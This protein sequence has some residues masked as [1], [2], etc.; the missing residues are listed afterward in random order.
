MGRNWV[1]AGLLLGFV[2]GASA[3]E[4]GGM[5]RPPPTDEERAARR[6]MFMQM[7]QERGAAGDGQRNVDAVMSTQQQAPEGG[8]LSTGRQA[9]VGGDVAVNWEN[10]T[11]KDCIEVLCRDL[12]MEFVISPSVNVAQEVSVRAGDVTKWAKEDKIELFDAILE[13]AGVQRVER[14]RIWIFAPSD[15]RPVVEGWSEKEYSDGKPVI[16][17]IRLKSVDASQAAEFLNTVGGKPQ[18]VF[19][20]KGSRM[21]LVLGTQQYLTQMEKLVELIDFPAGILKSYAL[22]QASSDDVAEEMTSL[23]YGR[24]GGDGDEIRFVS[25]ARLN[26]V[27]AHNVPES[28]IPEVDR[29]ITLLDSADEDHERY[30]KVYRL[31]VI[32]ADVIASTL[33]DLYSELYEQEQEKQQLATAAANQKAGTKTAT[34]Q[35]KTNTSK[36][37]SKNSDTKTTPAKTVTSSAKT[38]S[39]PGMTPSMDEE[40]IILSD[41]DTNTLIVNATPDQHRDIERTIKELDQAR[42]QVL[43]ETVLVEV[44]LDDGSDF[45]IEWAVSQGISVEGGVNYAKNISDYSDGFSYLLQSSSDKLAFIQAARTDDRLQ[46]LSSPTVLTRDGMEAEVSF[47]EEVPVLESSVS[48][49]GKENFSYDYRD[50]TVSLKV[51]PVIDDSRL[52]T[53]DLEQTFREVEPG[54]TA[55]ANTESYVA[56]TFTTRELT[57]NLQVE[58]GQT[59]VLG[60]LIKRE[61]Q[62]VKTGIPFLR[63]FPLIG[64]LFGSSSTDKVGS[65]ILMILTPHVVET[66]EETDLMSAAYRRKVF[67][68]LEVEDVRALYDLNDP[69]EPEIDE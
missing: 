26:T 55:T 30:T 50:A 1:A 46:V 54:Y 66:R 11:L 7:L 19:S 53:L 43:I 67:G 20:V 48:D 25:V 49:S 37:N 47:G 36:N 14:G 44:T 56:P 34:Q 59:L 39:A 68:S 57:S 15:I 63:S 8:E 17:V 32:T 16:G 21:L 40:A 35:S 64:W 9:T 13:T 28:M 61:D 58:D 60:G 18:K 41:E 3:Q 22:T 38:S 42:K 29:W 6:A 45:G 24:V 27:V 2:Y 12:E 10:I 23:F 33:N 52:V 65:E 4:D 31:Q 5:M 62:E 51:T 69:A